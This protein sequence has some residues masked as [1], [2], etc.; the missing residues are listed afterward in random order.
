MKIK[1]ELDLGHV[2]VS[3]VLA[4]SVTYSGTN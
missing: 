3:I 4:S 2:K 1:S